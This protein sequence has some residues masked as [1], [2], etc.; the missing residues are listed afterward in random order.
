MSTIE[1]TLLIKTEREFDDALKTK[2]KVYALIYATWC[3]FCIR[4]KPVFQKY[5]QEQPDLF[6]LAQ[7][8]QERLADRYSVDVVP[9]VLLFENG[10]P[11]HRLD[12]VLGIGLTEKLLAQF[13]SA[14]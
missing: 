12:G 5:A 14:H 9:T 3:P 11:T 6:L 1:S 8:D 4:F 2:D 7:D 13:I 10:Q